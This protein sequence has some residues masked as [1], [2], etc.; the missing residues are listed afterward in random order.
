LART[1]RLFL[2]TSKPATWA[3]PA[4]GAMRAHTNPSRRSLPSAVWPKKPEDL[5]AFHLRVQRIYCAKISI[6]FCQVNVEIPLL[7]SGESIRRSPNLPRALRE[8][9]SLFLPQQRYNAAGG[10]QND[11]EI[12]R[13]H[14][15]YLLTIRHLVKEH[16]VQ[17]S[18]NEENG[19]NYNRILRSRA[20]LF[21]DNHVT[22]APPGERSTF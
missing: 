5:A 13:P 17:P 9:V 15:G 22:C 4:V 20:G 12:T 14:V 2:R 7:V 8:W 21:Q 1:L 19:E 16:Q 18:D 3:L 11:Q 6:R 10:S